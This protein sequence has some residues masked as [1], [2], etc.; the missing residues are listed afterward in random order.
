MA[1]EKREDF[2]QYEL[3][4]STPQTTPISQ[5]D[6][7][8]GIERR[9][10]A[11]FFTG[12][13]FQSPNFVTG[14]RGWRITSDGDAE[15]REIT[16]SLNNTVTNYTA[17]QALSAFEAVFVADATETTVVTNGGSTSDDLLDETTDYRAQSF[18]VTS[19]SNTLK[20]VS[21]PMYRNSGPTGNMVIAL[22]ATSGGLPTGA[23]LAS[24][25]L[26]VS[27]LNVGSATTKT[28]TFNYPV[29]NSTEYAI[30]FD[31]SGITFGVGSVAI[32][33][34]SSYTGGTRSTSTDG[35]SW[36]SA[37]STDYNF[38]AILNDTE[39]GK[40]YKTTA[41]ASDNRLNNYVGI[42][43]SA[44]AR[45]GTAK[46]VTT[47]LIRDMSGLTTGTIYYL[48]D[49]AGAIAA[50]AGTVSKKIGKAVAT[51]QLKLIEII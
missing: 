29:S 37:G 41:L 24:T 19:L 9:G 5:Q 16:A 50:S 8:F 34:G 3:E 31:P 13:N 22:R 12:G 40:V 32:Q 36:T 35:S 43:S 47:G 48:S 10:D 33:V 49:T 25:T 17:G 51:T 20:S 21:F 2:L 42:V 14:Q 6:L 38:S 18:T 26:D 15:F 11:S 23:N 1:A 39:T 44:V 4:P 45:D 28:F 30:V 7:M 46:V 27:T